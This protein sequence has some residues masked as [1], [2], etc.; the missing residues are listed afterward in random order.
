MIPKASKYKTQHNAKNSN[1]EELK[2]KEFRKKAHHDTLSVSFFMKR[3]KNFLILLDIRS[4]HNVGSIF[5]TADAA[6]VEKI[7]L[8]GVTPAPI[9]RFGRP[10]KDIAKTALGA[11]RVVKWEVVPDIHPLFEKLRAEGV[12]IVA[13]EQDARARDYKG[14]SPSGDVAFIFGN[15]VDGV[16]KE[17][18]DTCDDIIE[19]PMHGKKE[20]L[21]VSVSVGVILFR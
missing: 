14:L 6:G 13:V 4:A 15:E 21:N 20:S 2:Y 11:E 18:L 5:R 16:S 19:I 7:Y 1:G 10:R 17:V 12:R 8:V 3:A 9:D